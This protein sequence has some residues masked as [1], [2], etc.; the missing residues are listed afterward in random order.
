MDPIIDAVAIFYDSLRLSI[1]LLL[2]LNDNRC[3]N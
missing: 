1:L 3:R 2:A